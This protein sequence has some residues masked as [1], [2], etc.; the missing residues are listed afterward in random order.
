MIT[1]DWSTVRPASARTGATKA[2]LEAL[3]GEPRP[4]ERERA[5]GD[6]AAG[7]AR[8]AVEAL[9]PA[10]RRA[11]ARSPRRGRA[12][13]CSRRPRGTGRRRQP[14]RPYSWLPTLCGRTGC[15][16]EFSAAA[17]RARGRGSGR[18]SRP[19]SPARSRSRRSSA[20]RRSAAGAAASA[21]A[22]A[23]RPARCRTASRRSAASSVSSGSTCGANSGCCTSSA[24]GTT[25]LRPRRTAR[26][27]WRA[28]VPIQ[29]PKRSRVAQAADVLHGAQPRELGDVVG[30][31]IAEAMRA[32]DGADQH[33]VAVDELVPGERLAGGRG[34]HERLGA[35]LAAP[36][37]LPVRQGRDLRHGRDPPRRAVGTALGPPWGD[38]SPRPCAPLWG[39]FISFTVN[40]ALL[41]FETRRRA[42]IEAR[43]EARLA[44]RAVD[45]GRQARAGRRLH[46][47]P[48][49]RGA[50][51]GRRA[52]VR[53]VVSTPTLGSG[54]PRGTVTVRR[55]PV[56][57][58]IELCGALTVEV[59]GRRSRE[60]CPAARGGCCSRTS[61][62]TATARSAATS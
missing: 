27:S 16:L 12:S 53:R 30:V 17:A 42:W 7:H 45:R 26:H 10:A 11:A 58:R 9:E 59:D 44:Y 46:R 20:R 62:S 37:R 8:D 14:G 29:A 51:G 40:P 15:V 6:R 54:C 18:C 33:R 5:R 60:T 61:R 25:R 49:R 13:P 22:A 23:A 56:P 1:D 32:A 3:G 35:A 2:G 43:E 31:G 36:R 4:R 57:T 48:R 55:H 38:V 47:L 28:V 21:G 41:P 24:V 52:G 50:R 39:M 19:A 34:R